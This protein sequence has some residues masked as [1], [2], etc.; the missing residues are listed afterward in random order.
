MPNH[1][2]F[3]VSVKPSVQDNIRQTDV[4][5]VKK[6]ESSFI[7]SS[8]RHPLTSAIGYLLSTYTQAVNKQNR[9]TG[10]LFQQK[11]KAKEID[12]YLYGT[13][14]F[15]YIH[16]NPLKA[17]LVAKMEDWLFS[18]FIDYAGLRTGTLCNQSLAY[19]LLNLNKE[20]FYEDAYKVIVDEAVSNI[21]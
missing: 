6:G 21:F 14:C 8:E 4:K 12:R 19:E 15:H 18:S 2:H 7:T 5:E 13:A 11:T 9:T 1:F 16:Q 10:S 17:G 3:L 20:T